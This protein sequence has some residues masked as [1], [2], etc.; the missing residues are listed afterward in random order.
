MQN[1]K[2]P[3]RTEACKMCDMRIELCGICKG[4]F[5]C[6][7]LRGGFKLEEREEDGGYFYLCDGCYASYCSNDQ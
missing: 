1:E 2:L 4:W 5:C 6:E 7:H 3:E